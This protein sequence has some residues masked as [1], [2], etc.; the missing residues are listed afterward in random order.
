M[1]VT[2][3]IMTKPST[4]KLLSGSTQHAFVKGEP[5]MT[6]DSFRDWVNNTILSFSHLQPHFPSS[7]SLRTAVHWLHYL[8]FKPVSHKKGRWAR[9]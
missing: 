9:A 6:A 7:I 2:V 1:N 4:I 3:F 8:G 5:N